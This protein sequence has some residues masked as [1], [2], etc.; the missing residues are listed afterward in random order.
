MTNG[1][2][3]YLRLNGK[4]PQWWRKLLVRCTAWA[5]CNDRF[6]N[7]SKSKGSGN[8]SSFPAS[9]A[10]RQGLHMGV[11][12]ILEPYAA[13]GKSSHRDF[14][15]SGNGKH[16]WKDLGLKAINSRE[17]NTSCWVSLDIH[18][19]FVMENP[20]LVVFNRFIGPHRKLV[21]LNPA[22]TARRTGNHGRL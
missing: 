3:R 13:V 4:M 6:L 11:V 5:G 10:P 9:W 16:T 20:A 7:A 15:S 14:L 12:D 19:H 18:L 2:S 1:Y 21:P 8:N 17:G 22:T